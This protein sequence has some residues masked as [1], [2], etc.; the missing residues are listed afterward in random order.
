[1]LLVFTVFAQGQV[2]PPR[3]VMS[4]PPGSI[5]SYVQAALAKHEKAVSIPAPKVL[6]AELA[7]LDAASHKA[8]IVL[9][10]LV[11]QVTTHD[12]YDIYTWY[13][14][15]IQ[16]RLGPYTRV[17][18]DIEMPASVPSALLP[19]L[20]DEFIMVE[21]FG[22]IELDGVT[23]S[24]LDPNVEALPKAEPRLM[25]V[26]FSANGSMAAPVFGYSGIFSVMADGRLRAAV[27]AKGNILK[28]E[29]D[30]RAHGRL[31]DLRTVLPL[32]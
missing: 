27:P 17:R 14:F 25:F 11:S 6:H 21:P 3:S 26:Q 22:T 15:K 32:R 7:G 16:E 1:L 5:M 28:E 18:D 8:S 12:T 4:T 23:V 9:A 30:Q 31:N 2:T 24:C 29:I 20:P 10:D 19:V 13:K